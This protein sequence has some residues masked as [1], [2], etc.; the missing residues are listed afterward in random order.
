MN[1]FEGLNPVFP[2]RRYVVGL[3]LVLP[4]SGSLI[5]YV[6]IQYRVIEKG[7]RDLKPL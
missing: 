6:A 5:M 1:S 4:R 7:G 2:L 3:M